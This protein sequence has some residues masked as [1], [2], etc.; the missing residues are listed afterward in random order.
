DQRALSPPAF[1]SIAERDRATIRPALPERRPPA[2]RIS[3]RLP[4]WRRKAAYHQ[5]RQKA[6]TPREAKT[7]RGPRPRSCSPAKDN[8]QRGECFL[9]GSNAG[10][11]PGPPG[12]TRLRA[13][14]DPL[15]FDPPGPE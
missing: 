12:Q 5:H 1:E 7:P 13:P 2:E 6:L 11:A 15:F 3:G 4:H 9:D 8:P 10:K 14:P